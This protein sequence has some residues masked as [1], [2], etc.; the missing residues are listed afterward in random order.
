MQ[1]V[2]LFTET[3]EERAKRTDPVAA[4]PYWGSWS[5]YMGAIAGAGVMVGGNG[6]Q[7]PDTATTLR[8]ENGTRHVVDGPFADTKEALG[9]YVVIE[10][11]DLD[12]ALEW[13]ARAPCVGAGAV[14]VRPVM[15]PPPA[16]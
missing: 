4:G 6:L 10:V 5:A 3:A 8:I 9:G 16:G 11:A 12:A 13:A 2:L 15:A 7:G 14:E 1:Y